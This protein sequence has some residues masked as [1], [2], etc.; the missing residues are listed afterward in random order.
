MVVAALLVA[1]VLSL[2]PPYQRLDAWL[3]DAQQALVAS[4]RYSDDAIVVDIDDASLRALQ[5]Q[6][7][8]WPYG[9]D[10]YALV[11][12]YLAEMGARTVILD[13][14]L[15]DPRDKDDRLAAAMRRNRNVVLIASAQA[16]NATAATANRPDLD[17]VRPLGWVAPASLPATH[18]PAILAPAA[19]LTEG[20]SSAMQLGMV[21]VTED[22]DGVLRSI[23]LMHQIGD[24][25]L[26][27]L[28][29]A[30]LASTTGKRVIGHDPANNTVSYGK[31]IWPVDAAGRVHIAFP[32]NANSVLTMSFGQVASAAL[33]LIQLDKAATFFRGKTVFIGSTA[34][35][36]DRVNTPRGVISGT[37]MLAIAQQSLMENSVLAPRGKAANALSIG[38]VVLSF[39]FVIVFAR[40]NPRRAA[41]VL[42]GAMLAVWAI[43][44]LLLSRGQAS[45]LLYPLLAIVLGWIILAASQQ[46]RLYERN[47]RLSAETSAL[48]R[49]NTELEASANTDTLTGL[50]VR[51]AFLQRFIQEI[52]RS[53]RTGKPLAVAILDLDHFKRVNDTYGHPVGDLVLK[54]FA[55]V[56]RRNLRSIDIAGRWGG[57]EF[58]VL[59]PETPI[60][61]ATL[62]LDRIRCAI[63][64]ERFSSPMDALIVTMSAGLTL[65]DLVIDDPEEII[66]MADKALYE[67]K[68]SGRNRICVTRPA[69]I[70][71]PGRITSET[72]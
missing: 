64:E 4:E 44:L 36:S 53:R 5:P 57:E 8:T 2:T 3:S 20:L 37:L 46:R 42:A 16:V 45:A 70:S 9:R 25:S 71:Q 11:I 60:D 54:T 12:D 24:V 69:G 67:A 72:L 1:W 62:V 48:E 61:Q 55:E 30:V 49:A 56:L 66:G 7:G 21:S 65:F 51:R 22:E 41:L 52:D 43:N 14:L 50:M 40:E 29:L 31:N 63:A 39:L 34:H 18:W 28:P 13:I 10:T 6:F 68:E 32:R 19:T 59:L 15:A 35:Q 58:V 23:P 17:R 47:A 27:A 33:G 38:W 26:P